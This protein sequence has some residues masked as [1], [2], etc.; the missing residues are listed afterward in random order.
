MFLQSVR[1]AR[2]RLARR[3]NMLKISLLH[4]TYQNSTNPRFHRDS[5]L[6][7]AK[8]RER[9][10]YIFAMNDNDE[11]S[12]EA[13][14]GALRAV[15]HPKD[16]Y[17]T[18][19]QNWNSAAALADGDLLFVISDDL[20]PPKWWDEQLEEIVGSRDP[21]NDNFV[22]KV[23][24]GPSSEETVLRHPI[25][26]RN[27]YEQYGLFDEDFRGVYCDSDFTLRALLFSN[28]LDGRT[29]KFLHAHPHFDRSIEETP[30]QIKINDKKEYELGKKLFNKKWSP[31]Q[32]GL[33][34]N[35]LPLGKSQ[36]IFP[37]TK[38]LRK[39]IITVRRKLR[40]NW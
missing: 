5:W 14:R 31:V 34:L 3:G 1:L 36:G 38:Q 12:L 32:F 26:S 7:T 11:T 25:A 35:R 29:I 15:N 24:D 21:L 18:A 2:V 28:I 8:N 20:H 16:E 30:S 10:Q 17:S 19:V 27:Y 39:A 13:T 22:I 23:T 40:P 4:A 6:E 37:L 9:I 33:T